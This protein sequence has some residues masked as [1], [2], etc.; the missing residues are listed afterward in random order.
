M[1]T[2]RERIKTFIIVNELIR[3]DSAVL[4]G[5]SGGADSVFLLHIL[6]AL[7]G[8]LSFSL[9]ALHVNHGIRG[10]EAERDEAFARDTCA[11]LSVPFESVSVS[12]PE[13]AASQGMSLEEAGRL[14]RYRELRRARAEIEKKTGL[15]CRIAVAHHADDQ[16][17]TVLH[18][19]FRGTG[20]RGLRGMEARREDLI[21]PILCMERREI[22]AY[23]REHVIGFVTDSSNADLHYTRNRIRSVI[24][25]EAEKINAQ[26]REHIAD[27]AALAAEAED[28]FTDF[29][30]RFVKEHAVYT[31]PQ[32]G[33]EN[34][35]AAA[36]TEETADGQNAEITAAADSALREIRIPVQTMLPLRS[37]LRR[38]VL[39]ELVRQLGTP[40]KDWG[41]RHF[42]DME[43]LL[44]LQGG[45]HLD[46]PYRMS[47]DIQ[48]HW[49]ILRVNREVISMKRR[50]KS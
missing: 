14:L 19:L 6:Y 46:L 35:P 45:A 33:A 21:R 27:T 32:R 48:K 47:A 39:M 22:E 23:L 16:A 50:K 2:V 11:A 38:Y 10:A 49:L 28:Y 9:Y 20:L 3:K 15:S 13:Y 37:L 30:E 25:P 40:L 24:L 26:A 5:L 36:E 43:S 8:E 41:S 17:E 1:N 12:A 4:L 42:M 29:A 44:A 7:Q 18:N 31:K 34:A